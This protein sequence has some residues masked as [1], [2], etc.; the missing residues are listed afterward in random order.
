[1]CK[2]GCLKTWDMRG[3]LDGRGELPS[4]SVGLEPAEAGTH[5]TLHLSGLSLGL[6]S[7]AVLIHSLILL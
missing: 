2:G 4:I 5:G 6:F 3:G 7:R 1:M